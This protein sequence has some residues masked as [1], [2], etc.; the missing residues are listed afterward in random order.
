M[1]CI[2]LCVCALLIRGCSCF[3]D[4]QTLAN[5]GKKGLTQSAILGHCAVVLAAR[6]GGKLV[7]Y[8]CRLGIAYASAY[9]VKT[10]QDVA[11]T[12]MCFRKQPQN[13]HS[14]DLHWFS[15]FFF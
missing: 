12:R 4:A 5:L 15:C 8:G 13:I 6:I 1:D 10:I 14:Y 2:A 11:I 9:F 7:C 3:V